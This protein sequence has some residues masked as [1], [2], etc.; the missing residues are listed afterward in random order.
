M[1]NKNTIPHILVVDDDEI[2]CIY[3]ERE[4]AKLNLPLTLQIAKNGVEALNILT[5]DNTETAVIPAIIVLDLMMPKMNG[6]EFLQSFRTH[7]KFN[8]VRIFVL[9]TS[10]NNKDKIATQDFNIDGYFVKGTQ[11][12]DFLN[13]CKNVLENFRS[14]I[15]D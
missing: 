11:F 8:S 7:S 6:L 13:Q 15:S 12:E 14:Q 5:N 3:V 2:D 4:L 1:I 10:N 9:T